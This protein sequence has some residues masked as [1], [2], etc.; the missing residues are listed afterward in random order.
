MKKTS[1]CKICKGPVQIVG[2]LHQCL[3]SKCNAVFWSKN[4]FNILKEG[5]KFY[6]TVEDKKKNRKIKK[7]TQTFKDILIEAKVKKTK[8][9]ESFVYQIQLKKSNQEIYLK[10]LIEEDHK[11]TKKKYY[12]FYIGKTSRHPLERYLRHLIGY[13]SGKKIVY[14]Y[15]MALVNYEGPMK[16]EE[17]TKREEGLANHL[18]SK[19]FMV[20]QN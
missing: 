15:G 1:F 9:G 4:L 3:G 13:Q 18:R 20:Y 11:N 12:E 7:L 16:S 5:K 6:E 19:G 8:P 10:K 14:R 2:Y 17:A